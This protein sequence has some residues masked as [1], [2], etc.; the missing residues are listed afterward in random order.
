MSG[1]GHPAYARTGLCPDAR[2]R[3]EANSPEFDDDRRRRR[4]GGTRDRCGRSPPQARVRGLRGVCAALPPLDQSDRLAR[5][6]P[7]T[8]LR[9]RQECGDPQ[10]GAPWPVTRSA[11]TRTWSRSAGAMPRRVTASAIGWRAC[12]PSG[13][14]TRVSRI[15]IANGARAHPRPD[16]RPLTLRLCSP[17]TQS[18]SVELPQVVRGGREA[19]GRGD[20]RCSALQQRSGPCRRP[21]PLVG[22]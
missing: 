16:R 14:D 10:S 6:R 13:A 2:A 17:F 4:N 20:T 9:A 12:G 8:P 11:P 15:A 1:T 7:G 5:R 21:M 3:S 18:S 22:R 19:G